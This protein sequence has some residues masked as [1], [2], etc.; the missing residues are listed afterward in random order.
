MGDHIWGSMPS[1]P[2]EMGVNRQLQAKNGMKTQYLQS[3]KKD[4]GQI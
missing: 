4:Q 2:S 3:Y 1:I